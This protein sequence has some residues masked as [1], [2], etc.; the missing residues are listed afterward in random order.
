[1]IISP[2]GYGLF[3]ADKKKG[4]PNGAAFCKIQQFLD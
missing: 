3:T 1:M 2:P 4:H